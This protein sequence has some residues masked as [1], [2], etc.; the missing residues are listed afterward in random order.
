[1]STKIYKVI[2][3]ILCY[4]ECKC[5]VNSAI[6]IN[7]DLALEYYKDLVESAKRYDLDL[8]NYTIDE[9]ETSFEGYLNNRAFEDSIAIWIEEDEIYEELEKT[10]EDMEKSYEI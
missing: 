7:K 4:Y 3:R 10:N 8:D 1:M 6:F 9:S 5:T 2:S